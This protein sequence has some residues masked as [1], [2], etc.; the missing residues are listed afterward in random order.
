[1]TFGV[2]RASSPWLSSRFLG[3]SLV[4]AGD[5]GAAMSIIFHVE[6]ITMIKDL[7]L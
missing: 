1:M 2:R 6:G 4:Y 5:D 7:I 3:E